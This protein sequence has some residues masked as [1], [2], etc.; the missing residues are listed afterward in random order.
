MVVWRGTNVRWWCG[1][2]LTYGGGFRGKVVEVRK[3]SK[4]EQLRIST[5]K[6]AVAEI[7]MR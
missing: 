7:I 2:G 4:Q 6:L 5:C 1:G 3:I